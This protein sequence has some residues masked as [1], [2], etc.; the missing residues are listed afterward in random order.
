MWAVFKGLPTRW[1]KVLHSLVFA[2]G[3]R[4][5]GRTGSVGVVKGLGLARAPEALRSGSVQFNV[6]CHADLLRVA[7]SGPVSDLDPL[8]P[9]LHSQTQLSQA[10]FC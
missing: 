8:D 3:E 9:P 7:R 2:F 1:L 5:L 10:N 4:G 6:G